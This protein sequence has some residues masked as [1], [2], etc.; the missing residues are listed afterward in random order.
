MLKIG[1]FSRLG[2]ISVR[3]LRH[4]D[5]LGL[6]KPAYV[7]PESD[8]RYYSLDQLPRLHRILALK[9]LGLS[10][11]QIEQVLRENLSPEQLQGMLALKQAELSQQVQETQLRLQRVASRLAQIQQEDADSPYEVVLRPISASVIAS[12]R[13]IVPTLMD[14]PTYRCGAS[15]D[16]YA[17]LDKQR[18]DPYGPEIVLYHF[19][20]Y[21]ETDIDMEFGIPIASKSKLDLRDPIQLSTLTAVE[22]MACVIHEGLLWDVGQAI[23]ALFTWMGRN[24]YASAGSFR[25]V[26]LFGKETAK[27]GTEPVVVELQI[28]VVPQSI[29]P[30]WAKNL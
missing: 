27:T 7:D 30:Y 3:M 17:W 5:Q 16:L 10:L 14:M 18:L 4:Y 29:N 20:D 1:D 21:S 9:D 8:Y 19:P 12:I 25:E 2:Q 13:R 24:G 28:P 22:Q 26:H 11:D 6:I 15:D 23:T